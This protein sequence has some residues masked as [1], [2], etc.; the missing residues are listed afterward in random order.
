MLCPFCKADNPQDATFCG[1]CGSPLSQEIS[2]ATSQRAP[3]G[4][5]TTYGTAGD[6][7]SGNAPVK[8]ASS[9]RPYLIGGIIGA[10]IAAIV[11]IAIVMFNSGNAPKEGD[12]A[13]GKG[14]NTPQQSETVPNL[15]RIGELD[16]DGVNAY[17]AQFDPYVEDVV[18]W[19]SK[20]LC[21]SSN[22]EGSISVQDLDGQW[23]ITV[24]RAD[25]TPTTMESDVET[26]AWCSY[27]CYYISEPLSYES[28]LE[29][30]QQI[31]EPDKVL[32]EA[33]TD[34]NGEIIDIGGKA[35]CDGMVLARVSFSRHIIDD[36]Y[37]VY[38]MLDCYYPGYSQYD[39]L[40]SSFEK[41]YETG[42][43]GQY[44]FRYP[45]SL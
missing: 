18:T 37:V 6:S 36:K 38:M 13:M 19:S 4:S 27:S 3:S 28:C 14:S 21:D 32:F 8:P 2:I 25:G 12:D 44:E 39:G 33:Y 7:V 15:Q 5:Q 35:I 22:G 10:A 26:I 31:C 40:T 1:K 11:A 23:D 29:K 34:N 24:H 45:D 16:A 41:W 17:L 9:K 30:L 20:E 42:R 43:G